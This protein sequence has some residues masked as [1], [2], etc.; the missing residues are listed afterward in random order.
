MLRGQA[1]PLAL[2]TLRWCAMFSVVEL[3]TAHREVSG[4]AIQRQPVRCTIAPHSLQVTPGLQT[5]VQPNEPC[6][7]TVLT[8]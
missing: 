1:L 3:G 2:K 6:A 5:I 4:R 8:V 7:R